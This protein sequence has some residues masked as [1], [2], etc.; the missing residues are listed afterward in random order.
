[1]RIPI[2]NLKQ[3]LKQSLQSIYLVFGEE[4]LQHQE[5]L[6][7]IRNAAKQKGFGEREC[8]VL[9]PNDDGIELKQSL[10]SMGLF[11]SLRLIDCK[12]GDGKLGKALAETL[13]TL[14]Q[15]LPPELLLI[16]SAG[17][18]D[19]NL[20]KSA[21]FLAI[22]QKGIVVQSNPIKAHEYN[23]W[24]ASRITQAGLIANQEVIEYLAQYTSGNLLAAV[25]TLESLSLQKGTDNTPLTIEDIKSNVIAAARFTVFD[26]VDAALSGSLLRTS[27]IFSSLRN[28]GIE[29][30]LILWAL[31]REVR[32]IIEMLIDMQA[33][34]PLSNVLHKKGVWSSRIPLIT[35]FIKRTTLD[36]LHNFLLHARQ[37]DEMIKTKSSLFA[38][39]S[40]LSLVLT[41][42]SPSEW[43]FECLK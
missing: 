42:A 9:S 25:R 7:E 43:R 41:L 38:S 12:L 39:E 16:F 1:M 13:V 28:E 8:F 2:H 31:T 19:A 33:G 15:Q 6:D 20:Q 26:L 10:A 36:F 21:W 22:E 35:S 3:H 14:T 29:P 40:L 23:R 18:L 17:K 27:A 30:I 11:S 37:V 32:A 5:A 4:P 34:Q 24:L